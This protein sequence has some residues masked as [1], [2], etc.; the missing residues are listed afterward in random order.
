MMALR[1][2][3]S[4][5]VRGDRLQDRRRKVA[6]YGVRIL[7]FL[8]LSAGALIILSPIWWMFATSLKSM[9][10]IMQFPPTF[11]PKHVVWSNYAVAWTS[12]PFTVYTLNTMLIT[13]CV[14]VGSVVSNSFI[15]YGFAK[16]KFPGR[17]ALFV[18]MLGTMMIPGFVT[19]IPQYVLFSKIHWVGTYLPLI[20]PSFFGSPFFIFMLRQFYRTIPGELSEAAKIDGA[21]HWYIWSRIMVPL[22]RPAILTI[23]VFAFNGA[24]NDFLGPLLYVNSPSMYTLQI[25]LTQFQGQV[26]TDWNYLMAASILILVP[27]V[28]IFFLFQ[29]YFIQGTSLTGSSKG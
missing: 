4:R 8:V 5:L 3:D 11:F 29:K 6:D 26:A 14:V 25:G 10:E 21:S 20:V 16:L 12:A 7:L 24:W 9:N 18:V 19:M 28:L 22:T 13:G 1:I 17:D 2:T 15:A 23:A 27:S